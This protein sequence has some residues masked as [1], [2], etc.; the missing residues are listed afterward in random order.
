MPMRSGAKWT[1]TVRSG[2]RS[3]VDDCAV[4]AEQSVGGKKGFRLGGAFG[5]ATF[6]WSNGT[7]IAGQVAANRFDPPLPL[8][9]RSKTHWEW[10]GTVR[11]LAGARR[12]SMTADSKAEKLDLGGRK[13]STT[14]VETRLTIA[15]QA[16]ELDT[17]FAAGIG[18][19][20]QEQRTDGKQDLAIEL[21]S[22]P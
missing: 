6:A 20:R 9:D 5:P 3:Y 16:V 7:L 4:E 14:K 1:Y 12:A 18:I 17:W 2:F 21:L 15:G 22:G 10:N 8:L 19:V 13:L 11:G